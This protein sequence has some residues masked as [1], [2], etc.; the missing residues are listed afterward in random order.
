MAKNIK[1]VGQIINTGR[2]CVVVFREIPD[3]PN[4]CLIVYTEALVDWMHD[5]VINS[6]ESTS[7]Q[8]A[9]NFYEYAQRALFT[10][11]SNML[12]ALH[13]KGLLQKQETSNILMIPNSNTSVNLAEL[14]KIIREQNGDQPAVV[15][16]VD[17][18]QLSMA[19]KPVDNVAE[20]YTAPA[21]APAAAQPA[22]G[23]IDDTALAK[24]MMDQAK[25]FEAEAASLKEQAIALDPTLKP[26]R[27]RPAKTP[28]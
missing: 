6:V 28:A 7:A 10:D 8:A 15:P 4:S 18:D 27:G 26:K 25:T 13:A 11:G 23:A 12:Q 1:H 3:E 17:P 9:N 2:R 24:S 5:D 19:N 20:T 21:P 16:P 22:D 14:N